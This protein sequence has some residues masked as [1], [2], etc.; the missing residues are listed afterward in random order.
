MAEFWLIKDFPIYLFHLHPYLL[1]I[2]FVY[3]WVI[4]GFFVQA[5]VVFLVVW[6][7]EVLPSGS[8]LVLADLDG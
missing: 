6:A 7:S 5:R 1:L 4:C 3:I 2:L 8:F